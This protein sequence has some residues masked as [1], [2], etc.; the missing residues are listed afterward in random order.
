MNVLILRVQCWNLMFEIKFP[1]FII[2]KWV[3]WIFIKTK[4]ISDDE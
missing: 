3:N 1:S 2:L 4:I